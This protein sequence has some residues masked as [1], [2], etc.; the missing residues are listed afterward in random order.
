MLLSLK[1]VVKNYAADKQLPVTAINGLSLDVERGEFLII[2]GRSGSGKTTLLNLMGGLTKP[3]SGEILVESVNLWH[4]GDA[5]LSRLRNRKIG[6]VFQFPSLI[7]T[8]CALENVALPAVLGKTCSH[9]DARA[10]AAH[11]L[12]T[13]GL[14][15]KRNAYPRHLSAGQQQRLVIARALLNQPEIV[16]ADEATSN[17]DEQTEKEIMTLFHRIHSDTGVTIVMVAHSSQLVPYGTRSIRLA[18]GTILND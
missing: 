10:R 1:N 2:L 9:T 12:E 16:L 15:E 3:T 8:L 17:L 7:P 18:A 4:L 6:F 11:L 5:Q 13:V 14:A